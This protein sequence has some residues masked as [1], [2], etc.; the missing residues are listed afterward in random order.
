MLRMPGRP[1]KAPTATYLFPHVVTRTQGKKV[2]F[3]TNNSTKSRAGYMSKFQS[4]GLNVKAVSGARPTRRG[5]GKGG[6]GG[7]G[8]LSS[9]LG[10]G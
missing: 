10:Q 7:R 1:P 5:K 6:R 4:L 8:S 9:A 3:V 2:F